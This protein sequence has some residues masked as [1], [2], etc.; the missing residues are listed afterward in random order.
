MRS[1]TAVRKGGSV[2]D[3]TIGLGRRSFTT[4]VTAL[5]IVA[6][7]ATS[8]ASATGTAEANRSASATAAQE[9]KITFSLDFLVDG[10][11]APFY[12]AQ[13]LG[14]FKQENLN[15]DIRTSTGSS[16]AVAR[17]ASGKAQIGLAD[18]PTALLAVGKGLPIQIVGVLLLHSAQATETLRS[19]GITTVKGL[20]G[21][22]VG[23]TPSGAERD[24][25]T[26]LLKLNG[27][28]PDNVN[29][30][31]IQAQSGKAN[32]LSGQVDAVNFFP[33]IFAD[34]IK[35]VNFIPWYKYGLDVYGTTIIANT[36]FI[37]DNPDAV[38]GFVHSA[39][40]GLKYTF[41][42]PNQAAQ[43]VAKAAKGDVAFFRTELGIYRPYWYDP[44]LQKRGL[45]YMTPARWA[46]TQAIAVKYL[47]LP[48]AV[49]LN[50]LYT[51]KYLGARVSP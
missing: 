1:T 32:L 33:A 16:D 24:L 18:A 41:K 28:N 46:K 15:V 7:C 51:N 22:N 11:H 42:R 34:V 39:M 44:A 8:L 48:K 29:F 9:T 12:S 40:R 14:Y 2:L 3:S 6:L 35:Q 26:A 38:T 31:S 50:K 36:K 25:I 43:I 20:E 21:K 49:P 37:R 27:V 4:L 13:S 45:G 19:S 47:N 17:V 10:L 5:T 23:I 30:V